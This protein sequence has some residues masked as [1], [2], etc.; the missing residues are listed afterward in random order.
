MEGEADWTHTDALWEALAYADTKQWTA[1]NLAPRQ[2][3]PA[4]CNEVLNNTQCLQQPLA[5]QPVSA[6]TVQPSTVVPVQ[7]LH[8]AEGIQD[9]VQLEDDGRNPWPPAQDIVIDWCIPTALGF[10]VWRPKNCEDGPECFIHRHGMRFLV[11]LSL[12][13]PV[14]WQTSRYYCRVHRKI[15]RTIGDV[16]VAQA[17]AAEGAR[18]I[19]ALHVWRR[20]I[21]LPDV[22]EFMWSVVQGGRSSPAQV[23]IQTSH[24]EKSFSLSF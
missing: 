13:G 2:T 12:P 8:A 20:L 22:V 17:A 4:Q 10:P 16:L 11:V 21:L 6:E 3:A 24:S 19:P 9:D 7:T 15:M 23:R 5:T 18:L 14:Q 1:H